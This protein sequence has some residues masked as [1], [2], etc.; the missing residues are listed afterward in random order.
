[1]PKLCTVGL[2][3]T[4]WTYAYMP[5]SFSPPRNEI[6]VTGTAHS[7]NGG[8]VIPWRQNQWMRF[9]YGGNGVTFKYCWPIN[10]GILG[11]LQRGIV[12]VE[13]EKPR[14]IYYLTF[15]PLT[16]NRQLPN[17]LQCGWLPRVVTKYRPGTNRDLPGR[18][19]TLLLLFN[20]FCFLTLRYFFSKY[21]PTWNPYIPD[22]EFIWCISQIPISVAVS[23]HVK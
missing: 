1:M 18:Q 9:L 5:H 16:V 6:N 12:R 3:L 8:S 10:G 11:S 7:R 2:E 14:N 21:V 4:S 13:G 23:C 17:D 15:C 19:L 22:T 20:C